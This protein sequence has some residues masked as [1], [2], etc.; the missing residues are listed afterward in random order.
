[1]TH[2]D[3]L[4]PCGSGQSYEHCCRRFHRGDELPENA[5]QLMRSRYS[6]YV[7][8]IPEY[9]INT[10]HPA[11]PY[12]LENKFSWKRAK[13][14]F[15]R[16]SVFKRLEILDFKEKSPLASVTF[17]AFLSKGDADA[18]FTEISYFEKFK[19]KWM[20]LRGQLTKGYAPE[21]VTEDPLQIL[22]LAYYGEPVL[23]QEAAPVV[24][25]DAS[26]KLLVEEMIETMKASSGIGIAAPQVH[27]SVR[28]FIAQPP[29]EYGEGKLGP[30]E[31]EVF[32]NPKLSLPSDELCQV[33]EG[34]LSIPT[35]RAMVTRPKEVTIEYTTLEGSQNRKRVSGWEARVIQ[36]EYDHIDGILFIDRLDSKERAALQQRLERLKERTSQQ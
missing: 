26:I 36:H 7:L 5:L 34:C 23:Q 13:S 19:G 2:S 33:E 17:T 18:T 24:E 11:S 12:Y 10:T 27:R 35:I 32:I 25:I 30:G 3:N 22:S 8:N 31:I 14:Q 9:L 29:V 28:I 20:Y 6:A 16:E 1:M 21:V 15:S 4:C